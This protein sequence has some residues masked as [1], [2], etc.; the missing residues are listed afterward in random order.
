MENSTSGDKYYDKNSFDLMSF[1]ERV[2]GT[3]KD[4]RTTPVGTAML[5]DALI[6]PRGEILKTGGVWKE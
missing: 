3:Y 4:P 6:L 5:N 2:L 1:L